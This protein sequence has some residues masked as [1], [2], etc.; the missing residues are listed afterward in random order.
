[1]LDF[2]EVNLGYAFVNVFLMRILLFHLISKN[3]SKNLKL[4]NKVSLSFLS[5]NSH[6]FKSF[7]IF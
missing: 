2:F 6:I 4:K 1:M 3:I 7:E 5:P